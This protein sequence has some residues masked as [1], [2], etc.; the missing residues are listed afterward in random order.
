M[1]TIPDF[2]KLAEAYGHRGVRVQ[3][4]RD[5]P[6]V[7]A[8]VMADS[9]HLVFMDVLTDRFE[10]VYP[11]IAPEQPLTR[12]TLRPQVVAEEL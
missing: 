3:H 6:C 1:D 10:N 11:T 4:A 5:L 8:E 12:M 7:L 2:V 9:E